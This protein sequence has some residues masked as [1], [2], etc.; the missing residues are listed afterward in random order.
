MRQNKQN[1]TDGFLTRQDYICILALTLLFTVLVFFRLGNTFAP[2]SGY[3]MGSEKREII[4]DFGEYRNISS[5]S[6]FLGNL[7][8]RRFALSAFNEVTG[9]WEVYNEDAVAE[10][11]FAW[12]KIDMNYYLRYLGIVTMD[13]EAVIEELVFQ[14][15]EGNVITPINAA[16]YQTLFDEQDMFPEAKTYMSGTMFDEVYHARTSY[17]FLH[18]LPA[19]E[20]TH[21]HLGKILISLGIAVFGMNPFGWRVVV[22]LFGIL[23]VPLIYLFAKRL[24]GDVF[25]SFATALLLVF[26]CM[27]FAL[28]RI[29]TIDIIAGFFILLMYYWMYR[30]MEADSAYRKTKRSVSDSFQPGEVCLPL[31]LSGA[32]MACGIAT[33]WTGIYAGVGLAV[34]FIWYTLT[35]YP[36]KQVKKL[37]LFCCLFFIVLP[38]ALYTLCFIPVVGYEEYSGLMDKAVRGTK[39]MFDY[40]A[41]LVAEHYYSSPFYEWP[42]IWMPLLYANDAVGVSDVSAVSCMGNPAI[43]WAGIPCTFYVLYRWVWKKDKK[44]GFLTIAYLAQYVPWMSVGRIT[45]IYHYFPSILFVILMMGYTMQHIRKRFSWGKKAVWAYLV[46]AVACFGIFYPVVSGI[47]CHKEWGLSLRLLKDWILVL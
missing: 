18:G 33:K 21:P 47:P 31:A 35:H 13:D 40:H 11:V 42:V 23:M 29:G 38:L 34:L 14:D 45:F 1:K 8:T 5:V 3:T 24:S 19:Y 30:Y 46:I 39:S 15:P 26:D 16:E 2:E 20:T 41:N 25:T 43:W 6:V 10:S 27:H 7:N 37:F 28:S 36:K 17:E 22:A 4:L 32:A 12:N 9:E 44:A